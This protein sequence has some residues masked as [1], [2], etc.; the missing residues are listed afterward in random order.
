[1]RCTGVPT[2]FKVPSAKGDEADA[3]EE[4]TPMETEKEPQPSLDL[5]P[6]AIEKELS[7]VPVEEAKQLKG[8]KGSKGVEDVEINDIKLRKTVIRQRELPDG[9]QEAVELVHHSLE[10]SPESEEVSH[11]L[12]I[13]VKLNL[14]KSSFNAI[15]HLSPL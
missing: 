2:I 9:E 13:K 4:P 1:M 11:M 8:W 5:R 10:K 3:D 14:K 12:I 7:E 6:S 15:K